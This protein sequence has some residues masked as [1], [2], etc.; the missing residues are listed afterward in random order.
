MFAPVPA[1]GPSKGF[2]RHITHILSDFI[3]IHFTILVT[4]ATN[5]TVM[6]GQLGYLFFSVRWSHVNC[7]T[8]E[9]NKG[10]GAVLTHMQRCVQG[11]RCSRDDRRQ[12]WLLDFCALTV[13]KWLACCGIFAAGIRCSG[14]VLKQEEH[15]AHH[16]WIYTRH[17][18]GRIH[19]KAS[20]LLP[21]CIRI[22]FLT[23]TENVL[24]YCQK[25]KRKKNIGTASTFWDYLPIYNIA[26][27]LS[28]TMGLF[29][30]SLWCKFI[31][32]QAIRWKTKRWFFGCMN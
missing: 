25:P 7:Q 6:S 8:A 11:W 14:I 4:M 20:S 5:N 23:R 19:F 31:E 30:E 26:G 3:C 17:S 24:K 32:K 9:P 2:G 10:S 13:R 15:Q 27:H 21:S 16:S 12:Q 22:R 28:R 18:A 1:I 29:Y